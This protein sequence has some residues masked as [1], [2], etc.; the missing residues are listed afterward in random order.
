M[1]RQVITIGPNGEVSGLQRK[2]GQGLNLQK[3]G[4]AKTTRASEIV[5]HEGEQ[6]WYVDVLQEAGKGI[7]T[8][9]KWQDLGL[10]FE[11]V[12]CEFVTGDGFNTEPMTF[13]EYDE[14]V[15]AEVMYLDALRLQG[16]H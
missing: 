8:P 3:F 4:Q 13:K 5:W 11:L 10:R 16:Q 14:A 7:L 1:H 9:K 12:A 6:Q 15:N 2:P